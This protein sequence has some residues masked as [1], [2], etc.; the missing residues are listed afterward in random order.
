MVK[1]SNGDP[2]CRSFKIRGSGIGFEGGSYKA[3]TISAAAKRAGSKLFQK[4]EYSKFPNKTSIKFILGETTRGSAKKTFAF[5]VTRIKLDK[6]IT[7]A[8]GNFDSEKD[9]FEKYYQVKYKFVCKALSA[10][11]NDK[12]VNDLIHKI[13]R[14]D[15]EKKMARKKKY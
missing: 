4:K 7:V 13:E 10:A 5:E 12:E 14:K 3:K 1:C 6:P 11:Q 2:D 8:R 9:T 15:E